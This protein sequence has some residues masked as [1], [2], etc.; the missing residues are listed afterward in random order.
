MKRR[1]LILTAALCLALC[2]CAWSNGV[3]VSVTPHTEK[4]EPE[5]HGMVSVAS[6]DELR[7]ELTGLVEGSAEKCA[8]SADGQDVE[9][10]EGWVKQA[11]AYV[12][13]QTPIG[14]YAVKDISYETSTSLGVAAVAMKISYR[15]APRE[16]QRMKRAENMGEAKNMIA[17]VLEQCEAGLV[18]RVE[19]YVE[20]DFVQL[21][22]SYAAMH[23]QI[24]MELPQVKANIYPDRGSDRVVELQFTYQNS[25]DAL[26]QMQAY[27]QQIF[28]SARFYV[29]GD[30]E[31]GV[32]YS[33]L[34]SFLME[35]YDYTV[36]TSLTPA[37]SL[38]RYAVGDSR[39]FACVYSAMCRQSGLECLT[40]TGTKAGE[41]RYW[42]MIQ[43][44][45]VY[46][47]VDLL[48]SVQSGGLRMLADMEM[49]GYVWD[50][51]AY[52]ACQGG[53]EAANGT[54]T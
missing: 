46:Y 49:Q 54:E 40:V 22:E 28:S 39:A 14:A 17:S 13:E 31:T 24:V 45:G 33:Q 6:Y 52:P 3:Y 20:T 43:V 47:H 34:Y 36:E 35:R 4:S 26:K 25:R 21:V 32:K 50:Y 12:T 15:Y 1:S 38:L 11:I 44:D 5:K 16:L 9:T 51:S 19:N 2:G 27:A 23:P 42:N 48:E 29:S 41:P 37:Y 18:L 10:L 30:E 53:V 8:L 7:Q